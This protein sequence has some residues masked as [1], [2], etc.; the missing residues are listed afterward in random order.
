M[1]AGNQH[2][3][4]VLLSLSLS[5]A[6]T[7]SFPLPLSPQVELVRHNVQNLTL[8]PPPPLSDM[9]PKQLQSMYRHAVT[10]HTPMLVH[11]HCS[12][13]PIPCLELLTNPATCGKKEGP[14]EEE[15]EEDP[16][17]FVRFSTDANLQAIMNAGK[18]CTLF[19]SILLCVFF[20]CRS[21]RCGAVPSTWPPHARLHSCSSS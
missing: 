21:P 17:I 3:G 14:G 13:A 6:L 7:L 12:T 20:C 1:Y 5:V 16:V 10:T 11:V 15:R 18:H 8:S 4:H 19:V 2:H 9:E